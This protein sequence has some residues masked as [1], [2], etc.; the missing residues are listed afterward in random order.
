MNTIRILAVAA[1]FLV[2]V[3]GCAGPSRNTSGDAT[4]ER[5]RAAKTVTIGI[6]REPETLGLI[7][8]CS[9]TNPIWLLVR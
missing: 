7:N 6:Q 4:G 5:P 8:G 2:L 1:G 3:S 9:W